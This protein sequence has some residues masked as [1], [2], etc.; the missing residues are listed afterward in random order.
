MEYR[1][2]YWEHKH[3]IIESIGAK[4]GGTNEDSVPIEFFL[5]SL[6][7]VTCISPRPVNN[8]LKYSPFIVFDD[9][10]LTLMAVQSDTSVQ[11]E[12]TRDTVPLYTEKI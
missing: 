4:Q 9:P 8:T 5:T 7:W 6:K 10:D 1:I 11:P 12:W 2:A 3:Y